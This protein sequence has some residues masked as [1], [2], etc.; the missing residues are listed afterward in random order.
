M[1]ENM[2]FTLIMRGAAM[3]LC[4][5]LGKIVSDIEF[6]FIFKNQN[7][8]IAYFDME[9][10]NKSIIRIKAYDDIADFVYSQLKVGQSVIVEGKIRKDGAVECEKL[11]IFK[12]RKMWNDLY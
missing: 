10:L 3:N 6:K 1:L 12:S 9:L 4:V 8:S 7:K 2:C 5:L 11:K